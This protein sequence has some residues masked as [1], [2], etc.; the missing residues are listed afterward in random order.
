M[1]YMGNSSLI[2]ATQMDLPVANFQ[3]PQDPTVS[4]NPKKL[5]CSWLN[6]TTG[7][8]WV[9]L[10]N[11][12]DANVWRCLN[13][14]GAVIISKTLASQT[15]LSGTIITVTFDTVDTDDLGFADLAVDD[16]KLTVPAGV[17]KVRVS[18]NLRSSKTLNGYRYAKVLK[19]G[20]LTSGLPS[21]LH[22]HNGD[23]YSIFPMQSAVLSVGTGD[24]FTMTYENGDSGD[25][26]YVD[27]K[28]T[29]MSV[30]VIEK[31]VQP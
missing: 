2:L 18:A 14:A 29:W 19:N 5:P 11:T 4:I 13:P 17:T 3:C 10:D 6:T 26:D 30:E 28:E 12:T 8:I 16:T 15:L 24:Y 31:M 20:L 22:P 27:S 9:C 23:E 25:D 7:E 1:S 21:S